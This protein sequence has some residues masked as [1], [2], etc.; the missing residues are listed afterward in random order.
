MIRK[1]LNNTILSSILKNSYL[2]ETQIDTLLCRQFAERNGEKIKD[3][4]K[5]R[6]K[7]TT[8]GS[9][10]R[11]Y[12]QASIVI[13]KCILTLLLIDLLGLGGDLF[14]NQLVDLSRL[15]KTMND[16]RSNDSAEIEKIINA[17][18]SDV[19]QG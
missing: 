17:F 13:R 8:F 5:L 4:I 6:D 16:R 14:L 7:N 9:F 15:L 3:S 2:S 12:K 19:V 11:S 1:Y 10:D 18:V